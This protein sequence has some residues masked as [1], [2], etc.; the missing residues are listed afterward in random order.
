MRLLKFAHLL[1]FIKREEPSLLNDTVNRYLSSKFK[2]D[3]PKKPTFTL[4]KSIVVL[5]KPPSDAGCKF[6]SFVFPVT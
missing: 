2:L 5:G 3:L 4:S 1:F 6:A